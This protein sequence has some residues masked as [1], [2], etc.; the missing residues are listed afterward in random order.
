[1]DWYEIYAATPEEAKGLFD[2]QRFMFAVALIDFKR[3]WALSNLQPLEAKINIVKGARI[4]RPFQP[5]LAWGQGGL[6]SS[7]L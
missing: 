5:A 6:A 3:A 4:T 2:Y 7:Q 1:M